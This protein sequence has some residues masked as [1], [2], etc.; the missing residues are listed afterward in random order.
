MCYNGDV[1][2]DEELG[3]VL[4]CGKLA[5]R[6][7]CWKPARKSSFNSAVLSVVQ[8]QNLAQLTS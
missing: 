8:R 3:L 2:L 5:K 4:F 7:D 6:N 1:S